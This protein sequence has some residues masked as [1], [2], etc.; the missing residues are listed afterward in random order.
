MQR[1]R[2]LVRWIGTAMA[3]LSLLSHSRGQDVKGTSNR[4]EAN[5][6]QAFS[7]LL[8][9]LLEEA[10]LKGIAAWWKRIIFMLPE[11]HAVDTKVN[12]HIC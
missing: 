8:K 5:H 1:G 12:I 9:A 11:A 4:P 7:F 6:P 10:S 3:I 2:R